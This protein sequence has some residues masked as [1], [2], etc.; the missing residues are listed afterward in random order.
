MKTVVAIAA[1]LAAVF[2]LPMVAVMFTGA[3]PPFARG[4]NGCQPSTSTTTSVTGA[5]TQGSGALPANW[6]AIT[7][8]L[9]SHSY[10]KNAAAGIAGNV[11]AES[12]GNPEEL[13]IG[14]GGGT[15][16]IQWTPAS[17]A[18]PLQPIITGNVSAD[19]ATQ[20]TDLLTYNSAKQASGL[21]SIAALNAEPTAAVAAA[22]YESAFEHPASLADAP[23]R[24]ANANAVLTAMTKGGG[25][26]G[27][28]TASVVTKCTGTKTTTTG[29]VAPLATGKAAVAIAYAKQQL[30]KP[31]VWG[32][33]GPD[34]F[35]CSGL[36]MEAW[37]AAG[38]NI[39]RTSEAQYAALPH[40][41]AAQAQPG[42]L[43]FYA[44]SDGTMT[45]PGHVVMY[46]GGGLVIQ[47][48]TTGT[49]IEISTLAFM[50][51]SQLVGYAR[52]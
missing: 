6:A 28:T 24:S 45:A 20:L 22:Y 31:Y 10:S 4:G 9:T 30:G 7:S 43:I 2:L 26:G 48:Y 38:V 18:A 39:P 21:A 44:G 52:P 32:G 1:V 13:Q 5:T 3:P 23:L 25:N 41:T 42:D 11:Q 19:L 51:P 36:V 34:G 35:D 27:V 8:F 49:P 37:Q 15:G 33:T 12:G 40:I 16:I 46:L 29:D 47:A 50:G 17:S 14:G